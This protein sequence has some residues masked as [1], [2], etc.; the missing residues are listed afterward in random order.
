MAKSTC[1][2]CDGKKF[3]MVDYEP[4]K[5]RFGYSFVQCATCGGVVGVVDAFN[6]VGMLQTL[7]KKL[8]FDLA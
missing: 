5:S 6:L 7:G 8:G 3:E 1:V 2:K 4:A